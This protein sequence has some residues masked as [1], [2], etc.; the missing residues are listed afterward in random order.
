MSEAWDRFDRQLQATGREKADGYSAAHFQGMT[1][2]EKG[3]A[4]DLLRQEARID[5]TVAEWLFHLEPARAEAACRDLL[6]QEQANPHFSAFVVEHA[7][8]KHTQDLRYQQRMIDGYPRVP[9]DQKPRALER[10]GHTPAS[11][12]LRAFFHDLLLAETDPELLAS[13]AYQVLLAHEL[14]YASEGDKTRF[15][16]LLSRLSSPSRATREQALRALSP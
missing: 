13:A 3:R 9:D 7:L 14:P 15:R 1:A 10:L 5:P 11:P 4:F 2:E 6:A 12:A 8:C 16:D